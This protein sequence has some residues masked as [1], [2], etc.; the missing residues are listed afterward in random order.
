MKHFFSCN[1]MYKQVPYGNGQEVKISDEQKKNYLEQSIQSGFI[2]D[3]ENDIYIREGYGA[4]VGA[5]PDNC[6]NIADVINFTVYDWNRKKVGHP[7]F[8]QKILGETTKEP[9]YPYG[10][11]MTEEGYDLVVGPG[12]YING[13]FANKLVYCQNY[14]DILEAEKTAHKSR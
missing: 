7:T 8:M 1:D 3:Q 2:V 6:N 9:Y 14:L 13:E 10:K 11:F 5:C 12:G 4:V